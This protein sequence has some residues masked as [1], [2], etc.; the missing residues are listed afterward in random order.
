MKDSVFLLYSVGG[1][2]RTLQSAPTELLRWCFQLSVQFDIRVLAA[3]RSS[4]RLMKPAVISR[5]LG[6][7]IP[8][9]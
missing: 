3:A 7:E 8:A 9:Y 6:S 5:L 1:G 4:Q 2:T